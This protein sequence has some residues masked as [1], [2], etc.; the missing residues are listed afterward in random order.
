MI[1]DKKL[2]ELIKLHPKRAHNVYCTFEGDNAI[3]HSLCLVL[4]LPKSEVTVSETPDDLPDISKRWRERVPKV[5]PEAAQTMRDRP[6]PEDKNEEGEPVE[7]I[8]LMSSGDDTFIQ[9]GIYDFIRDQ[10]MDAEFRV[11][12]GVRED[13]APNP[14]GIFVEDKLVGLVGACVEKADAAWL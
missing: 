9:L 4:E 10:L 12:P 2:R 7:V 6:W 11:Y 14:I 8:R 1:D 3:I 13:K 5:T